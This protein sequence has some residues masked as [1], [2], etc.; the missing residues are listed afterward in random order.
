MKPKTKLFYLILCLK[1][2]FHCIGEQ[3][4]SSNSST[5]EISDK[6]RALDDKLLKQQQ[7]N[8]IWYGSPNT[9]NMGSEIYT[10]IPQENWTKLA[11]SLHTWH[12]GKAVE[13]RAGHFW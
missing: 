4:N 7:M 2:I 9:Q 5:T 10:I 13:Y 11:K 8:H 12:P 3:I 6:R 1:I